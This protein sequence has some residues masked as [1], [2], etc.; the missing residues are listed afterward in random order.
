[1]SETKTAKR[2]TGGIIAIII[3][4]VCLCITTFALV[5]AHYANRVNCGR[6]SRTHADIIP[7]T[8]HQR[9]KSVE[10]A[11]AVCNESLCLFKQ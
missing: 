1:M 7:Q 5:Y 2:L 4:A 11:F 10:P 9:Y 3:L 6:L 8:V